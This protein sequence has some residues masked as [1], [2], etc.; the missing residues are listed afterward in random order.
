METEQILAENRR[1]NMEKLR[2]SRGGYKSNLTR[3]QNQV[4]DQNNEEW[5][6]TFIEYKLKEIDELL[7]KI[8]SVQEEIEALVVEDV[9]FEEE[10][11]KH[12][13][14]KKL[15]ED[16]YLKLTRQKVL[17]D[18][19]QMSE[20]HS[21]SNLTE[22]SPIRVKLPEL[23]L[24]IFA[25]D[26][27]EW[28]SFSHSFQSLIIQNPE[29]SDTQRF[30]YLK[31]CLK[32]SALAEVDNLATIGNNFPI[33]WRLLKE[34]FQNKKL[35]VRKYIQGFTDTF[36]NTK[37]PAESLRQILTHLSHALDSLGF[38][39]NALTEQ[40]IIYLV[41]CR[42]DQY[43]N[44]RWLEYTD[45]QSPPRLQQFVTFLEKYSQILEQKAT[46]K[47]PIQPTP[48][49]QF[50]IMNIDNPVSSRSSYSCVKSVTC[51]ICRE[52]HSIYFCNNFHDFS[53]Q[54][55]YDKAKKLKLCFNCLKV[56]HF[57]ARC[58]SRTNC[59]TCNRRHNSILHLDNEQ[60]QADHQETCDRDIVIGHQ[61][62]LPTAEVLVRTKS[63]E[64]ISARVLLDSG[65][66]VNFISQDLV[67]RL[68][69]QKVRKR[70]SLSSVGDKQYSVNDVV[71]CNIQ[72]RVTNYQ[73]DVELAVMDKI[74]QKV[75]STSL[76]WDPSSLSFD[77]KYC[78]DP[79]FYV[80]QKI[81]MLLGCELFF[82]II[83]GKKTTQPDGSCWL[84]SEL[85]WIFSGG[86]HMKPKDKMNL[87]KPPWAFKAG[88]C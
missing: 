39:T 79:Q 5:D 35:T 8:G 85:G 18:K 21:V 20:Y 19:E 78:A 73:T 46:L 70:I 86:V 57:R 42:L 47:N 28:L 82:Q 49:R 67:E 77:Q 41:E 51:V 7:T 25:G 75:P 61:T 54:E 87:L 56:G 65:S 22:T 33:A 27:T 1:N 55:K 63:G 45:T 13:E 53:V 83:K 17:L 14:I 50:R 60:D 26:V 15:Y 36:F 58:L 29:L 43:L 69:L 66:E 59:K 84:E 44:E 76:N 74:T 38:K 16:I 23:N 68:S 37:Q 72:S 64:V 80:S 48:S 81:D 34:R 6:L 32:G 10:L 31:S 88:E 40:L 11:K 30:I 9:E 71:K 4:T 62:V 52:N 12:T 2:R 24:P 3:I